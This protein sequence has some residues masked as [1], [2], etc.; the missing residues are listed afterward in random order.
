M[1]GT[2]KD[3]HDIQARFSIQKR[4][5]IS[6]SYGTKCDVKN[7]IMHSR[8]NNTKMEVTK[9]NSFLREDEDQRINLETVPIYNEEFNDLAK[10]VDQSVKDEE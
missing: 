6:K 5:V 9:T 4:K 1:N 7:Q 10:S 8:E 2:S 3:K